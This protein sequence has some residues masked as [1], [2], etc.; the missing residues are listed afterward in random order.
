MLPGR[1]ITGAAE[2]S[3]IKAHVYDLLEGNGTIPHSE[4]RKHWKA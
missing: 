4:W 2:V 3:A 1:D